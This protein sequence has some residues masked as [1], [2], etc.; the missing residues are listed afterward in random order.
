M[1][2]LNLTQHPATAEQVAAGVVDLTPDERRQLHQLLT[3]EELPSAEELEERAEEIEILARRAFD[4]DPHLDAV[5]IGGAPFLMAPLERSL[6]A[7]HELA[8]EHASE[9][10]F[11]PQVLYAFSRRESV[12]ERQ[13]DGSVRK[14]NVFRH[15]GFVSA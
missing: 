13:P 7:E 1:T 11:R 3:F 9:P 8:D 4:G 15:A 5:M 14:I 6:K 2:I 12:E 10:P